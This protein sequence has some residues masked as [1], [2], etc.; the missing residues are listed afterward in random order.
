MELCAAFVDGAEP[1]ATTGS[2]SKARF[3]HRPDSSAS[4]AGL[5]RRRSRLGEAARQL[6][7][8]CVTVELQRVE[9]RFLI[10][11]RLNL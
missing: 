3:R 11:A 5:S 7:E 1:S 2:V 6:L 8:S 9:L 10:K 4:S